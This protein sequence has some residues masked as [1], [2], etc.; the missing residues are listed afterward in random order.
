MALSVASL[1][2]LDTHLRRQARDDELAPPPPRGGG[3]GPSPWPLRTRLGEDLLVRRQ[4]GSGTISHPGDP[5]GEAAQGRGADGGARPR[6]PRALVPRESAGTRWPSRVWKTERRRVWRRGGGGGPS[7]RLLR[8]RDVVA[9]GGEVPVGER[10]SRQSMRRAPPSTFV[11]PVPVRRVGDEGGAMAARARATSE[12]LRN[13]MR[14]DV[15]FNNARTS[16]VN[17]RPARVR[18]SRGSFVHDVRPRGFARR[19]ETPSRSPGLAAP[20]A[21]ARASRSLRQFRFARRRPSC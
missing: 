15:T 10:K 7:R 3:P 14:L 1:T 8:L 18:I 17:E 6:A 2:V 20:V 19:R 5:R 4:R 16:F 13:A 11:R 9:R 12:C 21:F